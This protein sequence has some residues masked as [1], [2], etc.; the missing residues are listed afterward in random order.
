ME[1]GRFKARLSSCFA[2]T[3]SL[4][5]KISPTRVLQNTCMDGANDF[6]GSDFRMGFSQ[7]WG[8][9]DIWG[10]PWVTDSGPIFGPRDR[11]QI[12]ETRIF[13]PNFF[14]AFCSSDQNDTRTPVKF[15]RGENE[16]TVNVSV[17]SMGSRSSRF[18]ASTRRVGSQPG[19]V[20]RRGR[21]MQKIL[22][23]APVQ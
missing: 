22:A 13:H 10:I 15:D 14:F 6:G 4:S 12:D 8:A 21:T 11:I 18:R 16:S 3:K 1:V 5:S 9:C 20:N 17:N 23:R 19:S 7:R 2:V